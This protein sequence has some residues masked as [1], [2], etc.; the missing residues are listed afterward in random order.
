MTKETEATPL[1]ALKVAE[2]RE[3][4][5]HQ[6]VDLAGAKTKADIIAVIEESG[7]V[8]TISGTPY[9]VTAARLNARLSPSL[10]AAV[11][12]VVDQGATVQVVDVETVDGQEWVRT[13][14]GVWHLAE[15][16]EEV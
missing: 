16:L 7:Q 14:T 10:T 5:E 8:P 4:A 15:H 9:R 13:D 1:E 11:A 12:S 6:G 3:L 2:L